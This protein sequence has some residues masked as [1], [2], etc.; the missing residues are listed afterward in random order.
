[1]IKP[2]NGIATVSFLLYT[3]AIESIYLI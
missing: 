1:M 2:L 3:R